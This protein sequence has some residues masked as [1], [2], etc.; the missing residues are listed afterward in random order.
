MSTRRDDDQWLPDLQSE[1]AAVRNSAIGD[2]RDMLLRGL[3]KSLSKNGRVSDAFLEDVVQDAMLKI[4]SG[5]DSFE[6]RSKFR[7]WAVTVAVRTAVSQMRKRQ[8]Q[9]VSLESL[10]ADSDL[11]PQATVDA[12]TSSEQT[13]ERSEMLEKLKRLIDSELTE[14]QWTAITAELR[15]MPLTEL[16][17]KMGSNPNSLY[18]LLHDAR[19]KLRRGL[20]SAGI[21]MDD[22]RKAWA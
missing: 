13:T 5:L 6:G 18:K 12:S 14:K 9:D 10:T 11:N 1:D 15:G 20:E 2:L 3:G 16:A 19:K 7:T 21:T 8:W 22:V 4:L 17:E